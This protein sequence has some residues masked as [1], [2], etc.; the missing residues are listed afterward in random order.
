MPR[1]DVQFWMSTLLLSYGICM[2]VGALLT[3]WLSSYSKTRKSPLT[4]GL[5]MGFGATI[6]LMLGI[7]PW[8]L[9]VGRC[10]Q[11]L[12]A[13]IIYASGLSLISETVPPAV[14]GSWMG[15]GLSGMNLGMLAAPFLAGAVY[16]RAGYY[17]VFWMGLATIFVNLIFVLAMVEMRQG[18]SELL[19]EQ[20]TTQAAQPTEESFFIQRDA[21]CP[22][23]EVDSL[24]GSTLGLSD[25]ST[26][27]D[28]IDEEAPLL[29]RIQSYKKPNP[30]LF[31]TTTLLLRSP[32]ISTSV[33][34]AF[35]NVTLLTS[36]DAILPLFVHRTFH[37]NAA[38]AGAIFLTLTVPSM[39]GPA[40]GALAD[41]YGPRRIALIGF[42]LMTPAFA[43]LGLVGK[44]ALADIIGLCTLLV[45]IGTHGSVDLE[46]LPLL[47]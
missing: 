6:L 13:G 28:E 29:S 41:R 33:F 32:Q 34:G 11:G 30:P 3:G 12:C 40:I 27:S 25:A 21:I 23:D 19:E 35:L 14:V 7:A 36:F 15:F 38:A 4:V 18:L 47:I 8:M 43:L 20:N 44:A 9:I 42:A 24:S 31:H 10:M 2:T 5:I 22:R 45:F 17:P 16:A 39:T 37:W 26:T 1:A 46:R